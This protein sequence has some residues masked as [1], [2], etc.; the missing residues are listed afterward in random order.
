MRP[1]EEPKFPRDLRK[2]GDVAGLV[3]LLDDEKWAGL[4]A[5]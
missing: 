3:E 1:E 4:A 5:L 2:A